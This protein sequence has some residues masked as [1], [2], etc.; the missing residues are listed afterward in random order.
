[1][2]RP[3]LRFFQACIATVLFALLVPAAAVPQ[4]PTKLRIGA[5]AIDIGGI[6]YYALD[7]GYFKQA[8]LDVEIVRSANGPATAAAIL[9][10]TL[11]AGSGNALSLAEAHER[12]LRF[13]FIAPGGAFTSTSPTSGLVAPKSSTAH[14]AKDFNNKTIAVATLGSLGEI[15]VRAWLDQGGADLKTIK[16][17]ELPFSA[18]GPAISGGRV[19]GAV[20]EDPA[21]D[22]VLAGGDARLVAPV[23]AAIAPEFSEGGSFTTL[24]FARTHPDVMRRYYTAVVAACRWANANQAAS[25]KILEKYSG[26]PA[27]TMT[28]RV[29]YLETLDAADLQPLVNAAARY[30]PLKSP[31]PA[32]ELIAPGLP[33]R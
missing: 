22:N 7:L 28:H 27:A 9:G 25:A 19:D 2:S 6:V 21:L 15:A 3:K 31:F 32:S 13:V 5:A 8:G 20:M 24:E 23:Y 1:M 12:G 29:H 11:D 18:M 10:G 33:P 14:T 16:F 26:V 4:Q 17:I 30:G